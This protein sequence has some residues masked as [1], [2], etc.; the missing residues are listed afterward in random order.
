MS[1]PTKAYRIEQFAE[2]HG[3]SRAQVYVEIAEG[4]LTAR[5][6]GSRT[7][8][9]DEDAAFWRGSLPRMAAVRPLDR[10]P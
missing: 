6:I 4:R 3:I 10:P 7:V 8:V 2:A 9:T 5:K 1:V